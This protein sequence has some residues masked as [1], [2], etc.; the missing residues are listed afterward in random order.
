MPSAVWTAATALLSAATAAAH[1]Y[2]SGVFTPDGKFHQGWDPSSGM[3]YGDN[4]PEVVGWS[5]TV[6][7]EGFVSTD[8]YDTPDIACH[9]G[10][11]PAALSVEIGAGDV[12]TLQWNTW[13]ESHHGPVID[14]LAPCG[15]ED[16]S[17]ADKETLEW[18][19]ISGVGCQEPNGVDGNP[20]VWASDL[21]IANNNTWQVIIPK[22]LKP[23]GYV[24]RHE[25]IALHEP[26]QPQNYPQ[27]VNLEI[28]GNGNREPSGK[29]ATELYSASEAGIDFDIY[30]PFDD[31][32]VPGPAMIGGASP[33]LEQGTGVG[34]EA[35]PTEGKNGDYD[36]GPALPAVS[37]LPL[38]DQILPGLGLGAEDE[39]G[40]EVPL[41]SAA[42]TGGTVAEEPEDSYKEPEVSAESSP[43]ETR[44]P[45]PTGGSCRARRRGL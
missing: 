11:E 3:G 25:I 8:S 9:R 4:Y 15:E 30:T 36:E 17:K 45:V 41:E 26:G 42:A 18:F 35:G 7:D 34:L 27:C 22:D 38:V 43:V 39:A 20:G 33:I 37:E 31:Y 1:G 24:L 5:T 28:T 10:A 14:Y 40:D 2:V 44:A 12:L 16:C 23:G 6:Q 21:L 29:V 32:T 13:P 19:K